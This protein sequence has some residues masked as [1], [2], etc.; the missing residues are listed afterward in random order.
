MAGND[1]Y[2]YSVPSDV[3]ADDVR[4]RDPT[5]FRAASG[6]APLSF[7]GVITAEGEAQQG[8]AVVA[9]PGGGASKLKRKRRLVPRYQYV[10]VDQPEP[11]PQPEPVTRERVLRAKPKI[12][13]GPALKAVP[14]PEPAPVQEPVFDYDEDDALVLLLAA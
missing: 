2:L 12:V 14:K 1:V 9:S 8:A 13:S 4:L 6:A 10:R 11:E 5:G 7:V 3:D